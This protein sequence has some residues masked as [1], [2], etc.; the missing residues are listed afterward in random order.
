MLPPHDAAVQLI[1]KVPGKYRLVRKPHHTHDV[2]GAAWVS[3]LG[4][5]LVIDDYSNLSDTELLTL[6][7]KAFSMRPHVQTSVLA[8]M[9]STGLIFP[10]FNAT[11][12]VLT[13]R[14]PWMVCIPD[15]AIDPE[16]SAVATAPGTGYEASPRN[17]HCKS[18]T[19]HS[20]EFAGSTSG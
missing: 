7:E 17:R 13:V 1:Y 20:E 8:D 16:E 18:Q 10:L 2:E 15:G 6:I 14:W 12:T 19:P 5:R 11:V 9:Q 3:K 4:S